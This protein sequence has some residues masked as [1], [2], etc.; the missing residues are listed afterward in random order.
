MARYVRRPRHSF[1][2]KLRWAVG[3]FVWGVRTQSNFV[4]HLAVAVAVVVTGVLLRVTL[5]EWSVLALCITVVLVTELFNTAI[6]HL[7]RAITHEHDDEIRHALDTGAG[8]VLM[9]SVGSAVT[10]AIIFIN[11]L[12]LMLEWWSG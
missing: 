1:A 10:G 8:A 12:G 5:L 4:I 6:E 7:A 3:G 2:S 9:A 11:R